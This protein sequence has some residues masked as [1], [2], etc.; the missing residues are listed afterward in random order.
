MA[1]TRGGDL[2]V[3]VR[4]EPQSLSP[5]AQRDSTTQLVGLLT[6]AK[7]VRVNAATQELEPWLATDWAR[8]DD[9]LRFTVKLRTGVAFADGTPFTAGDVVFSLAAAYDKQSMLG[10]SLLVGGQKLQASAIDSHTVVFTLPSPFGP[11]LRVLNSLPIL[12]R[13]KLEG[14]LHAGTFGS[15]WG[16][17][18]P[19]GEITGL[20]PFVLTEY[21]TGERLVFARNDRYFRKDAAGA[22]L[23]Y[24]DRVVVEIVPEQD[25]QVLRLQAGQSDMSSTE[26]RPEDYAPLKRASERGEAQLLDVGPSTDLAGLWIN[27][28]PDAF[29]RDPRRSWIQREELRRAISLAVD[30]RVF[31]DTV[32]LGAAVPA[33]GPVTPA[34]RKWYSEDIAVSHD[35]EGARKLLASIDLRDRN[36]DGL[37]DDASGATAR[38]ALLTQ[39]GQTALERGAAVVR[40][41]LKR[42]GFTID[43]V[44]L[45]PNALVQ[46][47]LSGK[48][49]DAVYFFLIASDTDPAMN[50][51]FWLSSGGAHVWNPGQQ[52]PG[53][54]W[55]REIDDRMRRQTTAL[56]EG[57][58]RRVFLDV[59]RIFAEH[60]PMVHFAA[61]R[62]FV[63]ASPRV[64]NLMPG[65]SRPQLLW[66]ADTIAIKH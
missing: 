49:Y 42:I 19:P 45:E 15:A 56:D 29:A 61:P 5:Y 30:R 7:L 62:V 26:I 13:H 63:A 44:T 16:V 21:R 48:P 34:N 4:S 17:T 25:A 38:L 32:Y 18:T 14:A 24:L 20:G 22:P 12:P 51:D 1:A 8:A 65:V 23:P 37:L 10:D 53:T 54:A 35:P 46:T 57:E 36:G 55:E 59:Q 41:E 64:T 58:R 27:L 6:Q 31:V 3:S 40:D 47:F 28:R 2:V 33:F 50:L 11:G 60:L 39:K 52:A 66:S 43:V 9:G